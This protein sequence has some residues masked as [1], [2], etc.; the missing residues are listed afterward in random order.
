MNPHVSRKRVDK[1][2]MLPCIP[3]E[4][5]WVTWQDD[6]VERERGVCERLTDRGEGPQSTIDSA[7]SPRD[8]GGRR[9]L[10]Q[11][12]RENV[13]SRCEGD[14]MTL[15]APS[16]IMYRYHRYSTTSMHKAITRCH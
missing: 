15:R 3:F 11:P 13:E 14:P 1:A 9:S 8:R 7:D 2:D 10:E 4:G 6:V 12:G 16:R 5:D